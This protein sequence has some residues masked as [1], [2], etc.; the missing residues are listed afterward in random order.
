ML[1]RVHTEDKSAVLDVAGRLVYGEPVRDLH[2]KVKD[3]VQDGVNQVVVCLTG[4][5]YLDSSGIESLLAA[6]RSCT[7]SGGTFQLDQ[8]EG[9][10]RKVLRITRLEELFGLKSE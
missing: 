7:E 2:S 1:I 5:S 8:V 6:Y 3:L 4:V 9:A 10:P